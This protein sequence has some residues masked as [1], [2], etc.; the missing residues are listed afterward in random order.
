MINPF[1]NGIVW[2]ATGVHNEEGQFVVYKIPHK[3]QIIGDYSVRYDPDDKLWGVIHNPSGLRVRGYIKQK[4]AELVCIHV[5]RNMVSTWDGVDPDNSVFLE[6]NRR[7][8]SMK[9]E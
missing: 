4:D 3:A 6:E 8:V 5:S 2:L 7:L 1:W 9:Y